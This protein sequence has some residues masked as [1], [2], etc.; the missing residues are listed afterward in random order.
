MM[1]II[2]SLLLLSL[3][4]CE[5]AALD[6][7]ASGMAQANADMAAMNRSQCAAA[8]KYFD[9]STGICHFNL[10]DVGGYGATDEDW[11]HQQLHRCLDDCHEQFG[12][13]GDNFDSER[14]RAC[15]LSCSDKFER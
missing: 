5:P 13:D 11:R 10:P 2:G 6:A 14:L 3:A 15:R 1:R 8:G 9:P 7:F 4:G 12:T